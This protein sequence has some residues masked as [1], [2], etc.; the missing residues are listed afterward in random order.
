MCLGDG[1]DVVELTL[2]EDVLGLGLPPVIQKGDHGLAG[3]MG[4]RGRR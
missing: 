4:E 1:G 2:H 3:L